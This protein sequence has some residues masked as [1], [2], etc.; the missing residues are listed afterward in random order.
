MK[1]LHFTKMQGTGNDYVYVNGF[2]E[3]ASNPSELAQ[4]IS[5]RHFGVGS[6]GLVLVLPSTIADVRMRMFNADGSEAQMCGNAARCVGKY[7]YDHGIVTKDVLQLETA[8]GIK[9]MRLLFGDGQV[10]GAS[11]D[12]GL[13]ELQ[14]EKIPLALP[15]D[16]LQGLSVPVEVDGR[17]YH[18]TAMSMGNP[19]AVVFLDNIDALDLPLLGPKFENHA[20]FPQRTNVEF[21]QMCSSIK[22]RMRVWERGAGETLACGTGACAAAVAGALHGHT[23]RELEVELKGGVLRISWSPDNGHVYMTGNAAT[24]FDG[25]YFI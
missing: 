5:N 25:T 13:P 4:K 1:K 22:I 9:T 2:E 18:I 8:A 11:V 14:P 15:P 6:D 3:H 20:L 21:V 23:A 24:V 16:A 7:A 17:I 10:C 12:M 19:H